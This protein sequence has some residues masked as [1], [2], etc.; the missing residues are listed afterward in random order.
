VLEHLA[1]AER[2]ALKSE[3]TTRHSA[4]IKAA[5]ERRL[6]KTSGK[7]ARIKRTRTNQHWFGTISP[8]LRRRIAPLSIAKRLDLAQWFDELATE[9]ARNARHVRDNLWMLAELS[10]SEK[11]YCKAEGIKASDFARRKTWAT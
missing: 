6:Q 8:K 5:L 10:P 11:R 3:K 2:L 9:F 4:S 1:A 7:N